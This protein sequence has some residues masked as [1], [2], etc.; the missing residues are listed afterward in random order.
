MRPRFCHPSKRRRQ[1]PRLRRLTCSLLL[2][3]ALLGHS[4]LAVAQSRT[5]NFGDF[6]QQIQRAS[7]AANGYDFSS[8][9]YVYGVYGRG[10]TYKCE[11]YASDFVRAS[12]LHYSQMGE[13]NPWVR[14]RGWWVDDSGR[15]VSE[16]HAVVVNTQSGDVVNGQGLTANE[17]NG[18]SRK[19]HVNRY[20]VDENGVEM[21]YSE[22]EFEQKYANFQN[23][24]NLAPNSYG[25]PNNGLLGGETPAD[26]L[27]RLMM[28]LFQRNPG[29]GTGGGLMRAQGLRMKSASKN[30]AAA[31]KAPSQGSTSPSQQLKKQPSSQVMPPAPKSPSLPSSAPDSII[32]GF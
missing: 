17:W 2:T 11:N 19:F 18:Q 12:N 10:N 14:A 13:S 6:R 22:E 25:G 30:L 4:L 20:V 29:A 15:R 21:E 9:P 8:R 24:E 27:M 32:G 31:A 5:A 26:A 28:G 16:Y 7:I 23:K 1:R 3:V